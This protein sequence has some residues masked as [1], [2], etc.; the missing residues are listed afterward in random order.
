MSEPRRRRELPD[1]AGSG[2]LRTTDAVA[3][4]RQAADRRRATA[5]LRRALA[6]AEPGPVTMQVVYALLQLADAESARVMG[7]FADRLEGPPRAIV[8][9]CALL[10]RGAYDEL[11]T[12]IDSDPLIARFSPLAFCQLPRRI[13]EAPP[14]FARWIEQLRRGASGQGASVYRAFL[15]DV[16]EAAYRQIARGADPTTLLSE[17]G[18]GFFVDSITAELPGTTDFLAARGMV[19]LLGVLEPTDDTA[20]SAI[21]RARARFRNADFHEECRRILAG[22]P[23]PPPA[24]K[25]Q[26]SGRPR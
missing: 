20:R 9:S 3:A 19:W 21:E 8:E 5:R 11:A 24:P 16:A 6:A 14:L 17:E 25:T 1:L 22:E 26:S 2:P 10:V 7:A 15:G 23:W 13:A 18:C 12:R 4:I